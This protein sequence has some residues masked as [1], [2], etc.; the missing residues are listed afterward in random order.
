MSKVAFD[1]VAIIQDPNTSAM[2]FLQHGNSPVVSVC[3]CVC[4][5][6]L[7]CLVHLLAV[8]VVGTWGTSAQMMTG[9][10]PGP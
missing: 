9:Q 5:M 3:V 6:M 8:E 10:L 7:P 1:Q 2:V 4:L